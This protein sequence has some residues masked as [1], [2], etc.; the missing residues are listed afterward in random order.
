MFA[1]LLVKL[2]LHQLKFTGTPSLIDPRLEQAIH[3]DNDEPTLAG[4][5]LD[6]VVLESLRCP[7]TKVDCEGAILIC[8]DALGIGVEA[9][10]LLIALEHEA[11]LRIVDRSCPKVCNG[12]IGRDFE[13]I[14]LRAV[15]GLTV[16]INVGLNSLP[17]SMPME[18]KR[19]RVS[20]SSISNG[21]YWM[22]SSRWW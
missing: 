18:A 16:R 11:G 1:H 22:I 10:K 3:T 17:F 7:R 5:S 13:L 14:G 6:P 20:T 9:R 21:S 15:K 2:R 4:N 12:R 19:P 8:P